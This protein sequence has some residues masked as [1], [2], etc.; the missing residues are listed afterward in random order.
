[1]A[2]RE[3]RR[4]P[5]PGR[6]P[7]RRRRKAERTRKQRIV[8][9]AVRVVALLLVVC[10][11]TAGCAYWRLDHNVS[12]IDLSKVL[13]DADDSGEMNILVM[14]SDSRSGDNGDHAGGDTGGTSRSDTTAVVHINEDHTEAE[15]VWIPR[16]TLVDIPACTDGDGDAV[17]ARQDVMFNSAY[18]EGG[19]ECTVRTVEQMSGLELN[20]YVELDF[21][22]FVQFIDDIGGVT[23]TTTEDIDDPD[24]GFD[25]PAGTHHLD[26]DEA[27][28]FVR[29]RHG[30][31]DGSDLDRITLEQQMATA[32][33]DQVKGLDLVAHPKKAY[34][35]ASDLTESLTTDTGLDS[36][37]SLMGLGKSLTGIA[38]DDV[39]QVTLPT[40][41]APSDPNRIAPKDPDAGQVWDALENDRPIPSSIVHGQRENP[42]NSSTADSPTST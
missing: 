20:H 15:T 37:S 35:L 11:G 33:I 14:G 21:S 17:P 22:G 16:D 42:A 4:L 10:L 23:V 12:G 24:S 31:G 32:V 8:H 13:T 28:A 26:G 41:T 25:E 7:D 29:T 19:P 5:L 9:R 34:D 1:M 3:G 40:E 27:L 38:A 36:V 6:N 2:T 30:V 39:T 18:S